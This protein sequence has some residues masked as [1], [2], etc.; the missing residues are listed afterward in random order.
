M[1]FRLRDSNPHDYP[2]GQGEPGD[3]L[4]EHQGERRLE[5]VKIYLYILDQQM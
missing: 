4:R 5:E 2:G 3:L 1:L